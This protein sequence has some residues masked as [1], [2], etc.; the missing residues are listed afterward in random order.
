M[1]LK[2]TRW[3]L[4]TLLLGLVGYGVLLT[5]PTPV[6]AR[7]RDLVLAPALLVLPALV[8]RRLALTRAEDRTWLL[9]LAA[10]VAAFPLARLGTT[11]TD[12]SGWGSL[13]WAT[14]ALVL[15]GPATLLVGLVLAVRQRMSGIRV[16]VVLDGLAGAL[17]GATV[18]S[19]V[20]APLV[21]DAWDG[22]VAA[23]VLLG[24]P[25]LGAALSAAAVGALGLVGAGHGV[26]LTL[27]VNLS[28]AD[29]RDEAIV[30]T[31]ANALL[32]HR[33]P[34]KVLT[35][36]ISET[37]LAADLDRVRGV[38]AALKELG[39]R[40]A[41]D[42]YGT[43]GTSLE[44]LQSLPFD[45]IKLDRTFVRVAAA[46]PRAGGIVRATVDLTHALGRRMVA[47]G[48]EDR[49]TLD[50][51]AAMGCDLVQG[52]HLGRPM[53]AAAIEGVLSQPTGGKHRMLPDQ[54]TP[55]DPHPAPAP[56][57]AAGQRRAPRVS[58]SRS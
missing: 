39:V 44:A 14:D 43:G 31:V 11:V 1:V 19:L 48:V 51:L 24:R 42:D 12:L 2:E 18:A 5:M 10:G 4:A 58:R 22:S 47:E 49:F 6:P 53:I 17:A 40:L 8:L 23:G 15:A 26:P 9:T 56:G 55:A 57:A 32:A 3:L 46:S 27:T 29:L 7:G 21:H 25:L 41:L 38:I 35:I 13:H 36:D 34:A 45:D 50:L 52:H 20:V 37:G 28:G 54:P 33:L 30:S 16:N